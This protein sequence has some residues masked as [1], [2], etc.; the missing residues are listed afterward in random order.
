VTNDKR[1]LGSDKKYKESHPWAVRLSGIRQR[2]SNPRH[3]VYRYYGGRGIKCFLTI[4]EIRF[5]WHRDGADTMKRPSIDR[6]DSNGNYELSNCRFIEHV[7]NCKR[8]NFS[9]SLRTHCAQGHRS[10]GRDHRG[11]R[12]CKPCKAKGE[13]RRRYRI[14]AANPLVPGRWLDRMTWECNCPRHREGRYLSV[15]GNK[16][17]PIAKACG[18]CHAQR[19][20]KGFGGERPKTDA[21]TENKSNGK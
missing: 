18:F 21:P 17:L 15:I 8:A 7:E 11:R 20:R 4:E 1:V 3:T 12:L 16:M 2:C 10:W 6:I 9:R 13:M 19:P 14:A 5:L